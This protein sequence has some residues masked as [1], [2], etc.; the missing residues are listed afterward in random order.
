MYSPFPCN[1]KYKT[2][3]IPPIALEFE[4]TKQNNKATLRVWVYQL[5]WALSLTRHAINMLMNAY[6][7]QANGG[8]S[9]YNMSLSVVVLCKE[10]GK[11]A[12]MERIF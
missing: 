4:K 10:E 1:L 6:I 11:T 8:G 5:V 9:S 3:S 2:K 7:L 12:G